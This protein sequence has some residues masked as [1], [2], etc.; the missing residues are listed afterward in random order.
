MRKLSCREHLLLLTSGTLVTYTR[1]YILPSVG[2][3]RKGTL[4]SRCDL[5]RNCSRG[6]AKEPDVAFCSSPGHEPF[7]QKTTLAQPPWAWPVVP[8]RRDLKRS[9]LAGSRPPRA[10]PTISGEVCTHERA[11]R[12]L[13]TCGPG[14]HE[15]LPSP[16]LTSRTERNHA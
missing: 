13:H 7:G 5:P 14:S 3:L 11:P 1:K 16:Q 4:H 10:L 15:A 12:G 2:S 6:A 9:V 8:L